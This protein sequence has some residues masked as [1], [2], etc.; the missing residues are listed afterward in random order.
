MIASKIFYPAEAGSKYTTC[1]STE[2]VAEY[3]GKL[4][5]GKTVKGTLGGDYFAKMVK[6]DKGMVFK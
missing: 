6:A 3:E 5:E 1:M 4:A 2:Y